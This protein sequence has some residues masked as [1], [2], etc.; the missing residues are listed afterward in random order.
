MTFL[1]PGLLL[2]GPLVAIFLSLAL[3][4]QWRRISRLGRSYDDLAVQRLISRSLQG[5]P[6]GRMIC[7]LVVS[8]ALAAGAAGPRPVAPEPPEP[9]PP[10]DI[11]VA[12]DVSAS[13]SAGDVEPTRIGRAREV[14]DRVAESLPSARIV[15]IVF[16][17]WPYTL[18]PPTDDPAV[19]RYFARS[20]SADLVVDRDQGTSFSSALSHARAA[21]DA[22][23]RPGARRAI[24]VLSDGGAHED[25]ADILGAA[26]AASSDDVPIWT[27]GVG[28]REGAEL[29]TNAG[30]LLDAGG[31]T[32]VATLDDGLLSEIAR[33]GGGEYH[34]VS[35]NRG[36]RALLAELGTLDEDGTGEHQ[37]PMDL[38][39]LLTLLA[40][41]LLLWEGG[42]DAGRA[43]LPRRE[44]GTAA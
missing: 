24:L 14:I 3:T 26:T 43:A 32:V 35:N 8:L 4:F 18:V 7:L 15:L 9:A 37:G 19:V 1:R 33:A 2:L 29:T 6:T 5:F 27:A 12:V 42:S 17:D 40:V 44:R 23:S 20:L 36:V 34:D 30:P 31:R 11:A 39:F 10:L 41:P 28:T 22:R 13:M 21:L 25:M 38:T 16:A